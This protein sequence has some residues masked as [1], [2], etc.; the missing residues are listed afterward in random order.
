[1]GAG[2]GRLSRP[3]N[4]SRDGIWRMRMWRFLGELEFAMLRIGL[5]A[6]TFLATH[7]SPGGRNNPTPEG[8]P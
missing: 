1:M 7:R 8:V 5:S 6:S 4:S 3:F 2:P